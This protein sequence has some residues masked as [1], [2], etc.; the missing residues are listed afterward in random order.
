MI[1]NRKCC[2]S[3]LFSSA[4]SA[5]RAAKTAYWLIGLVRLSLPCARKDGRVGGGGTGRIC[6]GLFHPGGVSSFVATLSVP[7]RACIIGA[8]P[9]PAGDTAPHPFKKTLT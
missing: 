8:T 4:P 7:S 2:S 1:P 6:R 9:Q 5:S 3:I